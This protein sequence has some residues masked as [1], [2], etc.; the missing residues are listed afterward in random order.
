MANNDPMQRSWI[1][2]GV[3]ALLPQRGL[4]IERKR[5]TGESHTEDLTPTA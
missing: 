2:E 5:Y 3:D 4:S 1:V